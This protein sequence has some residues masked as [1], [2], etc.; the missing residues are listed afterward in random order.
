MLEDTH[1]SGRRNQ[2]APMKSIQERAPLI[3]TPSQLAQRQAIAAKVLGEIE[4]D[5]ETGYCLC[6]G[7]DLHSTESNRRDCTIYL[8]EGALLPHDKPTIFCFHQ[9]CKEVVAKANARLRS[10]IGKAEAGGSFSTLTPQERAEMQRRNREK[11]ARIAREQEM[12]RK[13]AELLPLLLEHSAWGEN[14]IREASPVRIEEEAREDWRLLL[15][16]L[17]LPDDVLWIGKKWDSGSPEH[18]AHFKT[19]A[20]WCAGDTPAGPYIC[21]AIFKAGCYAR[22]NANVTQSPFVV[23]EG[24]TVDP[25]TAAKLSRKEELTAD[26]KRRNR[27]ACGAVMN[28]LILHTGLTLRAVIDSGGKSLHFWLNHPG[29]EWLKEIKIALK[30]LGF[31]PTTLRPSQPVRLP[32]VFRHG[33]G[34]WQRLLF[35]S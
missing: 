29:D 13:A 28:W 2:N 15:E 18:A 16:G 8:N 6:P 12:Q 35:L 23:L 19:V 3:C 21:P 34:R 27:N 20:Q 26:D 1:E 5:G 24:D 31:D 32:G 30:S 22:T 33:E 17:Y 4:W 10:E 11:A 9:S 7:F 25:V 14:D